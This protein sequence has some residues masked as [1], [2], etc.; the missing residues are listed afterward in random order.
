MIKKQS[1]M[2]M[3]L[4]ERAAAVLEHGHELI[5]RIYM[6][7]C[8]KLYCMGDYHVELWYRQNGHKIDKI[9]VVDLEDVIHH[10]EKE[11]DISDIFRC[12]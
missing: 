9:Q 5:S 12:G 10:Y 11:I 6:F 1:F 3:C 7:Y 2:K 4:T 8:V